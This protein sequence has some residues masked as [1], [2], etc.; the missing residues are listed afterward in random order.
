MSLLSK[1]LKLFGR[2]IGYS[3]EVQTD[4]I[5]INQ[6]T[7][8]ECNS[9]DSSVQTERK[10][11]VNYGLKKECSNSVEI[12]TEYINSVDSSIQTSSSIHE[13]VDAMIN[14]AYEIYKERYI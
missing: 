1:L 7:Q 13:H 2:T 14:V 12:Q 6:E 4:L 9:V 5:T 10:R 8:T 3:V 11:N